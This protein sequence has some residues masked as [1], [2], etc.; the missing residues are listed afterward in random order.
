MAGIRHGH[1]PYSFIQ[2]LIKKILVYQ[3]LEKL[4]TTLN[5]GS[6]II[7]TVIIESLILVKVQKMIG[8]CQM[9][10][11]RER[12]V[13]GPGKNNREEISRLRIYFFKRA[14]GN[15]K[16]LFLIFK[17]LFHYLKSIVAHKK[18]KKTFLAIKFF[19]L[20]KCR[21]I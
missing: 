20:H 3:T 10:L 11:L 12:L 7:W 15:L 9:Q 18:F 1:T 14:V 17:M 19:A 16:T 6:D 13:C 2:R 8:L 5:Q 21:V 4:L